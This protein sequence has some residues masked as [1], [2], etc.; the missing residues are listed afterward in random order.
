MHILRLPN[1]DCVNFANTF[2]INADQ[3]RN[4]LL[5][6]FLT[7]TFHCNFISSSNAQCVTTFPYVEDFELNAGN[8]VSGGTSNGWAYGTP[9]KT[10]INTAGSGTKCW[11]T[12]GLTGTGYNNCERSYVESPCFDFST[13]SNPVVSMKIFW[14]CENT[15]DGATFQYSTNNGSSW[16]NVGIF[17]GATDCLNENWFNKGNITHLASSGGC[18]QT[19]ATVKHGWAG[20]VLSTT[21]SCQGGGGSQTWLIA[22]QCLSN[23]AGNPNVIFRFAF[24]AGSNCNN[25]DGFG[26][27]SISIF[28]AAPLYTANFTKNCSGNNTIQFTSTTSG[29]CIGTSSWNFGDPT[30]GANNLSSATNPQHT[31]VGNGPF[32]VSL[33]STGACGVITQIT[34]PV[35]LLATIPSI[36]NLTC[37]G[38]NNGAVSIN[39]TNNNGA[40]TYVLNPGAQT[41]STG[42]FSNLSAGSYTYTVTDASGCS[43]TN[44]ISITQPSAVNVAISPASSTV[45]C[46]INST[47]TIV[48]T[49]AGG[50]LPITYTLLNNG[51]SNN[52]GIF[53]NL[54]TGTYTIVASDNNNCSKSV[55][56]SISIS[57]AI[58]LGISKQEPLCA[59]NIGSIFAAGSGGTGTINYNLQPLNINSGTGNFPMA[60]SGIYTIVATDSKNCSTSGIVSFVV[61]NPLNIISLLVQDILCP[62]DIDGGINAFATGGTGTITYTV[63]GLPSQTN[64][65]FN[66]LAPNAYTLTVVDANN[67]SATQSFSVG[68]SV[69]PMTGTVTKKDVGCVGVNNDGNAA[70]SIAGGKSPYTY[71]WTTTPPSTT[72]AIT[73]LFAGTY[74]IVVRDANNCIYIDSAKI[75]P[76]TC[77]K[78]ISFPTAF[79]PNYDEVNDFFGPVT[80]IDYD[81]IAFSIYNRFGQRIF[82]SSNKSEKWDGTHKEF[83]VNLGTYYYMY[84][85]KCKEDGQEYI[86]KGDV[87]VVR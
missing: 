66:N 78:A 79:T 37:N 76:A 45:I 44:A 43:K 73:N 74:Y 4:F 50:V 84:Q 41:N 32:T 46:D 18:S 53:P 26:F 59:G 77:C 71:S 83:T 62:N 20:S 1:K 8:W 3:M 17:G 60:S 23:L 80:F 5:I 11:V 67:C 36:T 65:I 63:N 51:S 49:S 54:G 57:P 38:S 16:T 13:L 75:A 6:L 48:A 33:T 55:T 12:G 87:E 35:A 70:I 39:T 30:S 86:L 2:K 15:F 27:D 21:G 19:L 31:F 68:G 42:S 14:E 81:L 56:H 64:G 28:D 82:S 72:P 52:N 40:I 34:Q 24:G 61:P 58:N 22:K 9:N 69:V 85:Y 7:L 10:F 47:G 29:P 25:F